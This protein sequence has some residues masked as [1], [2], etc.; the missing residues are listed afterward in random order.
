MGET[1]YEIHIQPG[2][3][4]GVASLCPRPS[5]SDLTLSFTPDCFTCILLDIGFLILNKDEHWMSSSA[6]NLVRK[7]FIS[8][9]LMFSRSNLMSEVTGE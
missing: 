7:E 4:V 5:N 9:L 6:I 1:Y 2:A 3:E 8:E